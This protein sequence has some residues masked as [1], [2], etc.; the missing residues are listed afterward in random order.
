MYE[1]YFGFDQKPFNATPDSES[2]YYSEQYKEALANM[3]YGVE[4]RKGLILVTGRVGSGKTTLC[5]GFVKELSNTTSA[6]QVLDSTM[7][8][9]EILETIAQDFDLSLPEETTSREIIDV[10]NEFAFE[11]YRNGRN[12]CVIIDESQDLH[13]DALKHLRLLLN[14]VNKNENYLQIMLVGNQEL[15]MLLNKPKLEL[16]EHISLRAY[17]SNLT[18]E[19]TRHYLTHRIQQ[20]RPRKS[21]DIPEN[22]L[23]RL[24]GISA[25][26]PRAIDYLMDHTLRA[27]YRD[28]TFRMEEK[29]VDRAVEELSQDVAASKIEDARFLHRIRTRT[30]E[31][32]VREWMQS[33]LGTL[34][35][36][37]IYG[38]ATAIVTLGFL[39]GGTW[40]LAG[41]QEPLEPTVLQGEFPETQFT[42]ADSTAETRMAAGPEFMKR[43]SGETLTRF[44]GALVRGGEEDK[45]DT[46]TQRESES[47]T[48]TTTN[49]P[50]PEKSNSKPLSQAEANT[51]PATNSSGSGES[52]PE[53][54][55]V[56]NS[57]PSNRSSGTTNSDT[58]LPNL[59]ETSDTTSKKDTLEYQAWQ[60]SVA[61]QVLQ[62]DTVSRITE[63]PN[64]LG[65]K[66]VGSPGQVPADQTP[67]LS[68]ARY[69]S[70]KLKTVETL[71]KS[72]PNPPLGRLNTSLGIE[73]VV[74]D[75]LPG[76]LLGVE[77]DQGLPRTYGFSA[78]LK[79][80]P[81]D[82]PTR[83]VLFLPYETQ[84]WDPYDGWSV[85]DKSR[86]INSWTGEGQ[87]IVRA[88][89][90]MDVAYTRGQVDP[91][92]TE[93]QRLLNYVGDYEIP[94]VGRYGPLTERTVREFQNTHGL[95]SDGMAGPR[96]NLV[97]LRQ[98][99]YSN[100]WTPREYSQFIRRVEAD[101]VL[102]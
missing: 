73:E 2:I 102:D 43:S 66:P 1:S 69:I 20:A 53:A 42:M 49:I 96:T 63:F 45:T 35:Q 41:G 10:L 31:L 82:G 80:N 98:A 8:A 100:R 23:E 91:A 11:E 70:L 3:L 29:H 77:S 6:T 7:T 75:S 18:K 95:N 61:R 76:Q 12:V 39:I 51:N 89:L 58:I 34:D 46:M 93:L 94:L 83:T 4:E 56:S 50:N 22:V 57:T 60:K 81:S 55:S 79:W 48:D 17:L 87:F 15:N 99:G 30:N 5:R 72:L 85:V 62:E 36:P 40:F 65:I 24:Y 78:F 21:I 74:P 64:P 92:I 14:R 32:P 19:E 97:L 13:S 54:L 44:S 59:Y 16:K 27:A 26:N 101:A 90:E 88:D 37:W 33:A 86:F 38:S 28:E 71:P 67:M 68:L 84:I 9:Q 47:N 52:E 25:G